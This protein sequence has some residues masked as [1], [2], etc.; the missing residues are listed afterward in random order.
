MKEIFENLRKAVLDCDAQT[1]RTWAEKAVQEGVDPITAMDELT[2]AI[3]EVG[4]GYAQGTL[5]LP[6]LVGAAS[7]MKGA[8]NIIQERMR[9]TGKKRE[10]LGAI[11]I[12]TV[13]GDIHEIGKTMVATL[14]TAEGFE[15]IDLGVDV[16]SETFI[17]AVRKHKADIVAMSALLSTTVAEQKR[18]IATLKEEG[19][20]DRVKVMVGGAPVNEEYAKGI[21]ADGYDATAP[22]AVRVAKKLLNK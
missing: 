13:R 20:R 3:R 6:D 15:V 12:G 8:A 17:E 5:W 7:A 14:L 22:G 9:A 1:A 16:R 10:S 2:K 11:V 4:Q 21:G 18:V 19:L